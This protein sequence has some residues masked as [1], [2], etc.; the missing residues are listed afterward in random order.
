[1]RRR[2]DVFNVSLNA[3]SDNVQHEAQTKGSWMVKT[4]MVCFFFCDIVKEG[5]WDF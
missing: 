1:M 2:K 3:K 5:G 4:L